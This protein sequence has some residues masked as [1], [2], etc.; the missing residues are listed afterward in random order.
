MASPTLAGLKTAVYHCPI[1][2]S[3]DPTPL[4]PPSQ[5]TQYITQV[6][7]SPSI[8]QRYRP[9]AAS[10][11]HSDDFVQD[12]LEYNP[13]A[14]ARQPSTFLGFLKQSGPIENSQPA[15]TSCD[16]DLVA[17]RLQSQSQVIAQGAIE[18]L[19]LKHLPSENH[20]I[21]EDLV[22]VP[23]PAYLPSQGNTVDVADETQGRN[24][25][26]KQAITEHLTQAHTH[27]HTEPD[28][29]DEEIQDCITV[30]PRPATPPAAKFDT[31]KATN[32]SAGVSS[33]SRRSEDIYSV[34]PLNRT[35]LLHPNI[36]ATTAYTTP[37]MPPKASTTKGATSA[38]QSRKAASTASKKSS[39]P[40]PPLPDIINEGETSSIAILRNMRAGG[41]SQAN[42]TREASKAM[43]KVVYG[44]ETSQK[45]SVRPIQASTN[46][47]ATKSAQQRQSQPP[48]PS[49]KEPSRGA[50]LPQG[51]GDF[52]YSP[53][54][55]ASKRPAVPWHPE[56]ERVKSTKT[57][58]PTGASLSL[59]KKSS[60]SQPKKKATKAS[61]SDEDDDDEEYSAPKTYK[62]KTT[63]TTRAST[64]AQTQTATNNDGLNIS[65]RRSAASNTT[66]KELSMSRKTAP[67]HRREEIEDF[68]DSVTQINCGGAAASPQP[69]T[70]SSPAKPTAIKQKKTRRA[71]E[72]EAQLMRDAISSPDHTTIPAATKPQL[73]KKASVP[74][75]SSS[76]AHET[77]PEQGT[78]QRNPVN[79]DDD[80]SNE[81]DEDAMHEDFDASYG[82]IITEVMG[83]EPQDKPNI[84][85]TKNPAQSRVVV[86]LEPPIQQSL[87]NMTETPPD[88][89]LVAQERAQRKPNIVGFDTNGP[90]NQGARHLGKLPDVGIHD[91]P[92]E[93]A[94]S[95]DIDQFGIQEPSP[96]FFKTS[97]PDTRPKGMLGSKAPEVPTRN[98]TVASLLSTTSG[99]LAT[100][101]PKYNNSDQL[102]KTVVAVEVSTARG[103]RSTGSELLAKAVTIGHKGTNAQLIKQ[104]TSIT[105]LHDRQ[106]SPELQAQSGL[107]V[108]E[109]SQQLTRESVKYDVRQ[110]RDADTAR[111]PQP[112]VKNK[113]PS[114]S[115]GSRDAISV[116]PMEPVPREHVQTLSDQSVLQARAQIVQ[117]QGFE[118]PSKTS[119]SKASMPPA[120]HNQEKITRTSSQP[121]QATPPTIHRKRPSVEVNGEAAKRLKPG[122]HSPRLQS[123]KLA[124][125]K[126]SISRK[127]SQ[128]DDNGSPMPYGGEMSQ[129]TALVPRT[130]QKSSTTGSTLTNLATHQTT[131]EP[132]ARPTALTHNE[133][134]K[135]ESPLKE[136]RA[137][138][139]N[140]PHQVPRPFTHA[141]F[142]RDTQLTGKYL[143]TFGL[144]KDIPKHVS[145]VPRESSSRRAAP[146]QKSLGLLE[147][148]RSEVVHRTN[149]PGANENDRKES[150]EPEEPMDEDDPEKTLVNEDSDDGDDS[151]DDGSGSRN[152]SDTDGDEVAKSALSRWRDALESHQGDVYDQ[153]VRIAHR[154]TN[155]LKDHE[156]AIK[157][158]NTDYSQDGMKLIQR[159]VK[160]N[161]TKLEQ[162]CTKKSKV[163]GALVMGCERACGSLYKDTEDVKA[164]RERIVKTLQRRVDAVG[165]LDQILQTYQA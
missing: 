154:L 3:S 163:Q 7:R 122:N 106:S 141:G 119:G 110:H 25:S 13:P 140:S 41:T 151:D 2:A 127:L 164:S 73:N 21:E 37:S 81:D 126:D 161:E 102:R 53:D 50:E 121:S 34:T 133:M 104:P 64:R 118:R 124:A 28:D 24:S 69:T 46:K 105:S 59:S 45:S 38:S 107:L 88:L 23:P 144:H 83:Q 128:V 99:D 93:K 152:S 80:D 125:A 20:T 17:S 61:E 116:D 95:P 148:L 147:A 160:D 94:S 112:W 111:S 15:N 9:S 136:I 52:D 113:T 130:R 56:D 131:D 159:L 11:T 89:N 39:K 132:F 79:I 55:V 57:T 65:T 36:S 60:K 54:P 158:I 91:P 78:T 150:S 84:S 51:R 143:Q 30:H 96:T 157:D 135:P 123:T 137:L 48:V 145:P 47:P 100:P 77:I 44:T 153:L 109:H 70:L 165:K 31:R 146:I 120:E 22:Q 97:G 8:S 142:D 90:R 155:H 42:T 18:G 108:E 43:P 92:F 40:A 68:E 12:S 14:P 156:T 103:P 49:T 1:N 87:G 149:A 67:S 162:Y 139:Q 72:K 62:S 6:P 115:D 66:R 85:P 63:I 27:V 101:K 117:P 19:S 75:A 76:A 58:K 129:A 26:Q 71:T 32:S 10:Q 134:A 29:D 86:A 82:E 16:Q 114:N 74:R 33:A 98:N 4:K 138:Q 35:G 5:K